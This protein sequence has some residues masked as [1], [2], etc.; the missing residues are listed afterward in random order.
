MLMIVLAGTMVLLI[1]SC[2]ASVHAHE[3]ETLEALRADAERSVNQF[4]VEFANEASN[5]PYPTVRYLKSMNLSE[6]GRNQIESEC[7]LLTLVLVHPRYEE[8]AGVDFG[9]PGDS[10]SC[11]YYS[12]F[13][14]ALTDAGAV[15][16]VKVTVLV[17]KQ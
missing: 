9:G 5:E 17:W 16:V 14:N 1:S 15:G 13:L 4:M 12:G 10:T 2:W 3:A 7:F 11:G 6:W 8:L